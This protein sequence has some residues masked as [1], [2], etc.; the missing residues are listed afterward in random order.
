MGYNIKFLVVLGIK[1]RLLNLFLN[2][3][4]ELLLA[5][6]LILVYIFAYC[7]K[8]KLYLITTSYVST[9]FQELPM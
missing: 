7:Y 5:K 9:P 8:L 1:G 4:I 3:T 6:N 2:Y